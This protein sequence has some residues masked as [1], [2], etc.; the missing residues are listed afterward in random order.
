MKTNKLVILI[1]TI[2]AGAGCQSSNSMRPVTTTKFP[3]QY[4]VQE[5]GLQYKYWVYKEVPEHESR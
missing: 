2:I 3:G 5:A 1:L 4:A